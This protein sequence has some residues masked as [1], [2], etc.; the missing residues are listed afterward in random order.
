MRSIRSKVFTAILL[1]A[2]TAT[3][4]VAFF[5]YRKSAHRISVKPEF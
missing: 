3:L 4:A 5:S 1:I 2:L